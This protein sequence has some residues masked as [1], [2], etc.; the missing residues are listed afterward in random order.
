MEHMDSYILIHRKAAIL[1][2]S[3]TA[4]APLC[5]SAPLFIL[6]KKIAGFFI[7]IL[8]ITT[9]LTNRLLQVLICGR[10]FPFWIWLMRILSIF[11]VC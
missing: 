4:S 7:I 8:F 10:I 1:I 9:H 2:D 11:I 5:T 3:Q 6:E